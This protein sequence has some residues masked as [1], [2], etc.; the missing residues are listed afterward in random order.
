MTP[1]PVELSFDVD[2]PPLQGYFKNPQPMRDGDPPFA[3]FDLEVQT[4][5]HA[6]PFGSDNFNPPKK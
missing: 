3:F 5:W 4:L 6:P 1:A 2:T